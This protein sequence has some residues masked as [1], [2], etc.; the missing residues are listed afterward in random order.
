MPFPADKR[1]ALEVG[2]FERVDHESFRP[3]TPKSMS[4]LATGREQ[5]DIRGSKR[6]KAVLH[7]VAQQISTTTIAERMD[8]M[9]ATTTAD[10]MDILPATA[11]ATTTAKQM[12]DLAATTEVLHLPT[13]PQGH[14]RPEERSGSSK[15]DLISQICHS[16]LLHIL[17]PFQ[18]LNRL[19]LMIT[20]WLS[21]S[22]C[23]YIH[24]FGLALVNVPSDLVNSLT[25]TSTIIGSGIANTSIALSLWIAGTTS[26][27]FKFGGDSIKQFSSATTSF[28]CFFPIAQKICVSDGS[29]APKKSVAERVED[30]ANDF[31]AAAERN[32]QLRPITLNLV[33]FENEMESFEI[34]LRIGKYRPSLLEKL[35]ESN[36]RAP[37]LSENM[38][39]FISDNSASIG[40]VL[41]ATESLNRTLIK[42]AKEASQPDL[43][44]HLREISH[45]VLGSWSPFASVQ[46]RLVEAYLDWLNILDVQN[47]LQLIESQQLLGQFGDLEGRLREIKSAF[48][49]AHEDD[50]DNKVELSNWVNWQYWR[51]QNDKALRS[52]NKRLDAADK[53]YAHLELAKLYLRSTHLQHK[54]QNNRILTLRAYLQSPTML[55]KRDPDDVHAAFNLISGSAR[56]L[57][58]TYKYVAAVQDH[59]VEALGRLVVENGIIVINMTGAPT[60]EEIKNKI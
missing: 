43:W 50:K 48:T 30:A 40:I 26:D 60:K 7:P 24:A 41:V 22:I 27:V 9:L 23:L 53:N 46:F 36:T 17:W 35:D 8:N 12:D 13:P 54:E 59:H 5:T 33:M 32:V 52:I 37:A 55:I 56:R 20:L 57:K 10:A 38:E 2:N 21:F 45:R 19:W 16:I 34:S 3:L 39:N 49:S 29:F 15:L 18:N 44:Y 1:R 31:A 25:A 42:L 51:G 47:N 58:V 6:G 4:L 14:L 28:A 11:S